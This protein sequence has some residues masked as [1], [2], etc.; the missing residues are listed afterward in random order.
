MV[1]VGALQMM[2]VN[3]GNMSGA[4]SYYAKEV[5]NLEPIDFTVTLANFYMVVTYNFIMFGVYV[6]ARGRLYRMYL[7]I[8]ELGNRYL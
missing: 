1:V 4:P 3:G 7:A 8:E 2:E 5:M 6:A